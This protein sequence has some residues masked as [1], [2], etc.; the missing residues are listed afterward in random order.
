MS[1]KHHIILLAILVICTGYLLYS[2]VSDPFGEHDIFLAL[3]LTA[4]FIA[5]RRNKA[6]E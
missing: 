6:N 4:G 3:A 2:I 1:K 5:L